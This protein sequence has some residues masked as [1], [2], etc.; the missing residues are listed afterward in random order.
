M[1]NSFPHSFSVNMFHT[2]L[3]SIDTTQDNP[4]NKKKISMC[5]VIMPLILWTSMCVCVFPPTKEENKT[6]RPRD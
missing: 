6:I 5:N 2:A 4:Q 3:N 1:Y